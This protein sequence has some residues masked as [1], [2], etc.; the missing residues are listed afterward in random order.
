QNVLAGRIR[1]RHIPRRPLDLHPRR[2]HRPRP[3]RR[4]PPHPLGN[5]R[6]LPLRP[7][8]HDHALMRNMPLDHRRLIPKPRHQPPPVRLRAHR[9]LRRPCRRFSQRLFLARQPQRVLIRNPP[10][11][12][13]R[14]RPR[15]R[16]NRGRRHR[17]RPPPPPPPP[18]PQAPAVPPP[19]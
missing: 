2:V 18:P 13:A 3:N 8:V 12:V 19:P 16:R 1:P 7:D 6:H 14:T 10:R 11:R 5:A 4:Q 9:Q 15:R 17:P